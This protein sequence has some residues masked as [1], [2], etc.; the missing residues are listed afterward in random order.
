MTT[1]TTTNKTYSYCRISTPKQSM[2]RQINN[3]KDYCPDAII[4]E[5]EYTGRKVEGRKEFQKLLK[6]VKSGDTIIFDSVSRMSRNSEEGVNIYMDL[7][8]KGVNLIFLNEMHINTDTYRK[9]IEQA[10]IPATDNT[11]VNMILEGV[12]NAL[13]ELAKEQIRIAFNQAQKEVDDLSSRTSKGI[14]AKR[15]LAEKENREFKIGREA[16][17]KVTTKKSIAAKKEIQRLSKDFNGTNKDTEVIEI[18]KINRNTY[19]KYK[20]ELVQELQAQQYQ[21]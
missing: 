7:F 10:N 9:Q 14:E 8:D 3:V 21:D 1:K 11:I 16:G 19:Y 4:Y 17:A 5:E 18:L 6:R 20:K 12:V 2:Q 13:K 15:K